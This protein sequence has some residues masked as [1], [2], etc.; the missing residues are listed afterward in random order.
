MQNVCL[1]KNQFLKTLF[2]IWSTPANQITLQLLCSVISVPVTIWLGLGLQLYWWC[3]QVW[4]WDKQET[5]NMW[6]DIVIT[7]F[8]GSSP[9]ICNAG[10]KKK[11]NSKVSSRA[12][13]EFSLGLDFTFNNNWLLRLC[14]IMRKSDWSGIIKD[15]RRAESVACQTPREKQVSTLG[16]FMP[17]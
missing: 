3:D 5:V 16:W 11:G 12:C 7:G 15:S 17:E 1:K 6:G 2:V 8:S 4:G 14:W 13:L 9:C 10:H